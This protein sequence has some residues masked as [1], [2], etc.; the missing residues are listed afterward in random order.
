MRSRV[1][2]MLLYETSFLSMVGGVAGLILSFALLGWLGRVGVNMQAWADGFAAIG[3]DP[4]IYPEAT[5]TFYV[6]VAGMV[7]LTA[8]LASIYPARRALKLLPA[9]AIR[10]DT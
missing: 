6:Q 9:E 3:Y 7:L 8:I 10:S 4:M 5:P 1:F 2:W